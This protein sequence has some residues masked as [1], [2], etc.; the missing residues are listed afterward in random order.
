MKFVVDMNLSPRRTGFLADAG[1][2]AIHWSTVGAGTAGDVEIMEFAQNHGFVVLTHGLD[3][4]AS[5]AATHGDKPSVV[6]IRSRDVSPE[7]A[8]HRVVAGL[9]QMK[10]E[11]EAGA[12]MTLDSDRARLRLL[13]LQ[14][15]G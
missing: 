9:K 10:Q 15:F 5:L 8:G 13:P 3:F 2:S 14:P 12:V 7:V 4:R 6:Q 11:L 1:F